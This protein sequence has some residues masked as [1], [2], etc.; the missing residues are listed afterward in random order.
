LPLAG[1]GAAARFVF[2]IEHQQKSQNTRGMANFKPLN[3]KIFTKAKEELSDEAIYW[4]N[5]SVC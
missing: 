1:R 5:F 4:K 2:V 3:T